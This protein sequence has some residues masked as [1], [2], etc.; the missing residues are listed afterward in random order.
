[1]HPCPRAGEV[2]S[3]V[4]LGALPANRHGHPRLGRRTPT[5][6][7]VPLTSSSPGALCCSRYGAL[8]HCPG[9]GCVLF[10]FKPGLRRIQ[11]EG[12]GV[13]HKA[14]V[15]GCLSLAAPIGLSLLLILTLCG[16]E[17]VLVVSRDALDDLSCLTTQ[18]GGGGRVGIY[19]TYMHIIVWQGRGQ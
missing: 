11:R 8:S 12:G 10:T 15:S 16:S 17:R 7:Q 18:A 4:L 19:H 14:S 9:H 13:W 2:C 5:P 3:K 1:M 6:R